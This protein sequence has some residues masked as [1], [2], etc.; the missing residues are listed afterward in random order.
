M[1]APRR[2]GIVLVVVLVVGRSNVR[3]RVR[4]RVRGRFLEEDDMKH[5]RRTLVAVLWVL[6][7]CLAAH[8]GTPEGWFP[9]AMPPYGA[10][11]SLVDMAWLNPEPAGAAGFVTIKDGHFVD[12]G[13]RRLRL[14]GTN[15]TFADAF[16]SKE[17]A[18]KIAF[19]MRQFG[20]NVVRFHHIDSSPAPRGLWLQD[21]SGLDPQQLDLLDWFVFQ[22][23]QHGIYSNLNLHVSRTYARDINELDRAFRYGKGLDNFFPKFIQM[24][25]EYATALLT[26]RNP[27]TQTTYADEPAVLCF[28]INNE[29][30]LLTKSRSVLAALP[31]PYGPELA[32][33][34]R[35]WLKKRYGSTQALRSQ[36]DQTAEPLGDE[37]LTNRDFAQGA[38]RWS[39]EAPAPA[40]AAMQAV[41]G[42][43]PGMKAMRCELTKPG[44]QPWH[45]QLHQTGL[46]LKD[47]Q[48]YT[49]SFR[50]KA[51]PARPVS[52]NVRMDC[53]PWKMVGLNEQVAFGKDWRSYSYTFKCREPK[54]QHTRVS[55]NFASTVGVCWVADVSLRPGGFIGLPRGQS[56]EADNITLP[57]ANAAPTAFG[58]F[59]QFLVDTE[60]EYVA[61]MVRHLKDGLRAKP[62]VTHTQASYG[63]VAGL[64]REATLCDFVDI[65]AYWQHPHFPGKP[66][67]SGN[68]T[69]GNTSMVA[70]SAGGTL[71]GRAA[72]RSLG[73]PYTLSEYDHPAPS[74]YSAEMFPMVA[75]FAAL[76][77][78]DAVYQF[79]WGSVGATA[80]ETRLAGYFSL[81]PHPGKMA[82]L[83][84][85]A[86]MFRCAVVAA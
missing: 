50:G 43:Q 54:P 6:G 63:G 61:G 22:L 12:G 71:F 46:D 68:W 73:K 28:E 44:T 16:A 34:W 64:H 17:V 21:F 41:D 8:G 25:R 24:Q 47:N 82:F 49:L 79:C 83:P 18:T 42:P 76:Q 75:S 9:F 26:H 4:R 51:E 74:D 2:M 20:I 53:E 32:G 10:E 3:A 86:V 7:L 84:V 67:D 29:N 35:A 60:R 81:S 38:T 80:Q 11:G 65:H 48:T 70:S 52:V 57:E 55:F 59:W 39:L 69:I 56:L 72:H 5:S 37:I 40:Q 78:W 45:F 15:L 23:K 1:P 30:S 13:G 14:L 27:Y 31:E 66:W 36:W 85:A 33:Q 62:L 19:R 58:D 77:D